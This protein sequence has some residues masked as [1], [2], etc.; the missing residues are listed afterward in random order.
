[1]AKPVIFSTKE[2][3]TQTEA[4]K[5]VS[6]SI[7][8]HDVFFQ[9]DGGY[10]PLNR[11]AIMK[12]GKLA[13]IVSSSYTLIKHDDLLSQAFKAIRGQDKEVRSVGLDSDGDRMIA[14]IIINKTYEVAPGDSVRP[15]LLILN[16][17][18]HSFSAGFDLAFCRVDCESVGLTDYSVRWSHFGSAPDSIDFKTLNDALSHFESEIVPAL[19]RLVKG[20]SKEAAI[21]I[22]V[23]AEQEGTIP[24]KVARRLC[25]EIDKNVPRT[26]W[27]LFNVIA[28]EITHTMQIS[29]SYRRQLWKS[30]GHFFLYGSPLD[31]INKVKMKDIETLIANK[32]GP[33]EKEKAE[34]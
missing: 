33:R 2:K 8:M 3:P 17:Y 26:L 7:K 22:V 27:D 9:Q 13:E 14:H 20:I 28:A 10:V 12:G 25:E 6:G 19:K 31:L 15:E 16:S 21:K 23:G 1:M 30:V 18:D 4:I 34:S 11:K 32:R 5:F 29:P 24:K